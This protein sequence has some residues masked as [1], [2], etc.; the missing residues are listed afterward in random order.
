MNS[1]IIFNGRYI[2]E[3]N[4]SE[5]FSNRAF[6]YGDSLF[7]TVR[8]H[9]RKILFFE[10]HLNRLTN[11][12]KVLKYN[13]PE[14]FND[15]S[16]LENE[17]INL[18][19]RNKI[20]GAARIRITVFR[21][22]G[23]LYTPQTNDINYIISASNINTKN[24]ELNKT[25]FTISIFNE[26]KKPINIFSSF[27]TANSLIYTLAGIYKNKIGVDD[28]L[29]LNKRNEICES[30]SSNIFIVKNKTLI[31]PPLNSGCIDGIMRKV[32]LNSA[33]KL[34]IKI[35][36]QTLKENDLLQAEEIFLTNSISGIRWV[37]AYKNK[38]YYKRISEKL[39]LK[40]TDLSI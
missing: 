17:I 22:S 35:T 33:E 13:I 14:K 31:T 28:C 34:K 23:G 1:Y 9:N 8:V 15:K 37:V 38:R 4:I 32:L 20:F 12:M 11:G 39:F 27:K 5:C 19:N 7:E 30:I 6:L 3:K 36:E 10:Q 25:G 21:K 2:T 29:I 16:H 26:I 40:L 24:F 18:L